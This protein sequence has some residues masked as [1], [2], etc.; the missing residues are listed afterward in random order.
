M[1]QRF[2]LAEA[3]RVKEAVHLAPEATFTV[4]APDELRGVRAR[5]GSHPSGVTVTRERLD[6]LSRPLIDRT[7]AAVRKVLG[8]ATCIS[9][10]YAYGEIAPSERKTPCDLQN[11]TMTIT[12][13]S[14]V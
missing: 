11:Q 12:T 8:P 4:T 14:E 1:W 9:G 3:R 7:L 6:A 2:A 10:F 13:L 5:L